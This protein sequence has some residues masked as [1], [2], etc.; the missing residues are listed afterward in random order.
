[1]GVAVPWQQRGPTG[2]AIPQPTLVKW[3]V[4]GPLGWTVGVCPAEK[5]GD[6]FSLDTQRT[7]W[8]E[9]SSAGAKR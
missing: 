1:M 7:K 5:L 6:L 9:L 3:E 8:Q 2:P 4:D